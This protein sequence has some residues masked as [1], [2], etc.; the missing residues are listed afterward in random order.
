MTHSS[1]RWHRPALVVVAAAAFAAVALAGSSWVAS[2][3]AASVPEGS[4]TSVLFTAATTGSSSACN[5]PNFSWSDDAGL[6]WDTAATTNTTHTVSVDA[7]SVGGLG[8]WTSTTH[9]VRVADGTASTG[10]CDTAEAFLATTVTNVAPVVTVSA[11]LVVYEGTTVVRTCDA[12]DVTG[13]VAAMLWTW[14]W[15]DGVSQVGVTTSPYTNTSRSTATRTFTDQVTATATCTADDGATT[16][17]AATT[18]EASN[19]DPVVVAGSFASGIEGDTLSVIC[20]A[21][22]VAADVSAL[23][24]TWVWSDGGTSTNVTTSSSA[25]ATRSTATRTFADDGAPTATCTA[26][27]GTSPIAGSAIPVTIANR[28]PVVTA[29][30]AAS[31]TD[32]DTLSVTCD[33]VDIAADVSAM[34]WTWV[35]SDGGTS[36]NTTASSTTLSRSIATRASLRDGVFTAICTADDGTVGVSGTPI[37]VSVTNVVPVVTTSAGASG[38]EGDSLSVSCTATDTSADANAMAWTWVWSDGGSSSNLTTVSSTT[39]QSTAT[40]TFT[41]QGSPTATCTANDGT[42]AVAGAPIAVVVAN[43]APSVTSAPNATVPEGS[44]VVLTCSADDAPDDVAAML[45][46]WSWSDRLPSTNTTTSTGTTSVSTATRTFFDDT[47]RTASCVAF[48]GTRATSGGRATVTVT[49]VA[50]VITGT[51]AAISSDG[52]TYGFTPG[53]VDPGLDTWVWSVSSVSGVVVVPS[54]GEVRWTP[55]VEDEGVVSLTL[56]VVDDDGGSGSLAWD[57][58]VTA[59]DDDADGLAGA[60]ERGVT[61]TTR[62]GVVSDP[63]DGD[64]DGDGVSTWDEIVWLDTDGSG[65]VNVDELN[66]GGGVCGD[67]DTD[68]DTLP[69]YL[70][71]DDDGD[72]VLTVDEE[73]RGDTDLDGTPDYL[74]TDDDDDGVDTLDEVTVHSTDPQLVDTDG[75]GLEDAPEVER[76]CTDATRVDTDDDGLEDGFEDAN[77]DGVVDAAETD[78]CDNDTDGDDLPDGT[79]GTASTDPRDPDSDADGLYDGFEDANQDGVVGVSETSPGVFDTDGEGLGDGYEVNTSGTDPL[80]DDTDGDDLTDSDEVNVRGTSPLLTDTDGDT[81]AD[82]EEALDFETNPNDTDSDADGVAEA[83]E[84]DGEEGAWIARDTDGDGIIDALDD[85]DDGDGQPSF[86]EVA[87][88][89]TV[90]SDTDGI[91]DYRDDDDDGDGYADRVVDCDAGAVTCDC[92]DLSDLTF[93]GGVDL[94][95]DEVDQDCDADFGCYRDAD[96]DSFRAEDTALRTDSA[97]DDCDDAGEGSVDEPA[98]DCDDASADVHPYVVEDCE[99]FG[100]AQVDQDCNG[101]ANSYHDEAGA[102]QT[103]QGFGDYPYYVDQDHDGYGNEDAEPTYACEPPSEPTDEDLAAG[104]PSYSPTNGDCDDE[105]ALRHPGAEEVCNGLD[106]DCDD[107]A[108]D[109]ESLGANSGCRDLYEDRDLD[110]YGS[111][112]DA[113]RLCICYDGKPD[114]A[115]VDVGATDTD[116]DGLSD[117]DEVSLGTDPLD[118]DSDDDGTRDADEFDAYPLSICPG[119]DAAGRG[120]EVTADGTCWTSQTGDCYDYDSNISPGAIEAIDGDDNDCDGF[121]PAVELDCDD[122]GSL[123]LDASDFLSSADRDYSAASLGLAACTQGSELLLDCWAGASVRLTCAQSTELWVASRSDESTSARFSGGKRLYVSGQACTSD[124]DC[125]DTCTARCPTATEICDGI[126]NDCDVPGGVIDVAGDGILDTMQAEFEHLGNVSV[127][128]ID[129]DADGFIACDSRPTG[130]QTFPTG[131]SCSTTIQEDGRI[132]DCND[133]CAMAYPAAPEERC[134]GLLNVCDGAVEGVDADADGFATCGVASTA[135]GVVLPEDTYVVVWYTGD[136]QGAEVVV[137]DTG[138][139][140]APEPVGGVIPMLLPRPEATDLCDLSLRE[141]VTAV[142]GSADAMEAAMVAAGAGDW[143]GAVTPLLAACVVSDLAYEVCLKEPGGV[144]CTPLPRCGVVRL[145]LDAAADAGLDDEAIN[146]TFQVAPACAV[147]PEQQTLRTV[148]SRER[149]LQSRRLVEEWECFRLSGTFGCGALERPE[150]WE[151]A[152]GSAVSGGHFNHRPAA[153]TLSGDARWWQELN[154]F[155]PE[156]AP[157]GL[158]SGCWPEEDADEVTGGDC[159]DGGPSANREGVEG[160][161]DLLVTFYGLD[162]E[163]DTCLDGVDNNCNGLIDCDEPA[164]VACFAG[165]GLGCAADGSPCAQAGCAASGVSRRDA[166]PRGILAVFAVFALASTVRRRP[167]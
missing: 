154:R 140:G 69:D 32:G 4:T 12:V 59:V 8:T 158:L 48:D 76:Y 24:W 134:D 58:E 127:E 141:E 123:A 128:E 100:G 44:P 65:S 151:D 68:C 126:D 145:H 36:T 20:D 70:D 21:T 80:V 106:E 160:P 64:D 109:P 38:V 149:S 102:Q 5:S 54:S 120:H 90:D 39:S 161:A 144:D 135:D 43:N 111:T 159:A 103:A 31:G 156:A 47:S 157:V 75:D 138:D 37:A 146:P 92:D 72:A 163:C 98:T 94:P 131:A 53:L 34:T 73:V 152:Y 55:R 71:P 132:G 74:D 133:A 112:E 130:A 164:C 96:S 148:W 105:N 121:L 57:V 124:G 119:L 153:A 99:P 26:N 137:E 27:D 91:V 45:W 17:S 125:D 28:A 77:R 81:I 41:N 9:K 107:V 118:D 136:E 147:L 139:T 13:D 56:T 162:P 108:D 79:E 16:V 35:W 61:V 18:V 6:T 15:S 113:A 50:P 40:R 115:A 19:L 89:V 88:G 87:T 33:A 49:N 150:G 167:W 51:P 2:T 122:D 52:A 86:D 1:R 11:D 83:A 93:P 142:V 67:A 78:P 7:V 155:S 165:A 97:D 25:T 114:D 60:I 29:G 101:D 85:N 30:A 166:D 82:G 22:D 84:F 95:N 116:G 104:E 62:F 63:D 143:A 42:I 129:L 14:S 10:A 110:G 117:E 46:S 3:T 66:A 23:I